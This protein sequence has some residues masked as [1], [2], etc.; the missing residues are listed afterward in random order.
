MVF[1]LALQGYLLHAVLVQKTIIVLFLLA[2]NLS[3]QNVDI[4]TVPPDL[5]VPVLTAGKPSAGLR[6]KQTLPIYE[7]TDVYHVLYLPTNWKPS[8]KYPVIVE[9]A[10]NGPYR[11]KFGDVSTGHVEGSRLGYGISGGKGYIW[12]CLPYL[13]SAGTANVTR[14]WGSKPDHNPKPTINYCKA[15]VMWVCQ[16]YG[17]DSKR[18]VLAGFSRGA[19]ACNFIGLHDD[20]IAKLWSAFIP[21]SHYDGVITGWP[22]PGADRTSALIRLKRLGERPQFI[23]GEGANANGTAAY[24]KKTGVKGQFTFIGTGFRNHSDAWTLRPSRARAELRK[25]LAKSLKIS[26]TATE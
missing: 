26:V 2:G 4:S 25:W 12:L 15:A 3:A 6:V 24:L 18:V 10:G 16:N 1:I 7:K 17:G 23:C 19:I 8:G 5:K 13:N 20:E 11:N 22:Y 14:W 21:Y 9:F